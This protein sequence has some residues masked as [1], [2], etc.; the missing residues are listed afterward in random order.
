MRPAFAP[1]AALISLVMGTA[2]A[3][4]E[5]LSPV[6][7]G[8]VTSSGMT[9]AYTGVVPPGGYESYPYQP[10]TWS[11]YSSSLAAGRLELLGNTAYS[12]YTDPYRTEYGW[13][14][15]YGWAAFQIPEVDP[16]KLLSA[17]FT[18]TYSN[19]Y[20]VSLTDVSPTSF[21]S[22]ETLF[23]DVASNAYGQVP[24]GS[25]APR[26]ITTLLGGS[27]GNDIL[28][29]Q[30]DIFYVGLMGPCCGYEQPTVYLENISL[31]L[32]QISSVPLPPAAWLFATSAFGV[33]G[34]RSARRTARRA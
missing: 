7:T 27:I 31:S 8:Y 33:F 10:G 2:S 25:S 11:S 26:T 23:N 9:I 6:A 24:A 32:Q 15:R 17:A 14:Q 30:G 3:H 1:L 13:Y 4:S 21:S 19:G 22:A 20:A 34:W 16:L 5:T 18:A 12:R 28:A 29:R